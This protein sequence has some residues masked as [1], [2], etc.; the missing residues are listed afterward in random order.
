MTTEE[1]V[2]K[3]LREV[4]DPE[5]GIDIW[6]LGLIYEIKIKNDNL[7][8]KMTFTSML[9]PMG[10]MI[11]EDIKERMSSLPDIRETIVHVTFD[12]PWE[13]SEELQALMGLI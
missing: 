13:P 5:I 12:P 2:I 9:C 8:I 3:K 10:P 11:V 6:T 1:I 7:H 4:I